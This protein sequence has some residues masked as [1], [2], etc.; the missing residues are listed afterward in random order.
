MD[1]AAE[2]QAFVDTHRE[3]PWGHYLLGTALA[4]A[5]ILQF[6]QAVS[7]VSVDEDRGEAEQ[8]A[9]R[10]YGEALKRARKALDQ[11]LANELL[12]PRQRDSVLQRRC[13]VFVLANEPDEADRDWNEAERLPGGPERVARNSWVLLNLSITRLLVQQGKLTEA[14]GRL[15]RAIGKFPAS[16]LPPRTRAELKLR[17]KRLS[18]ED[19]DRIIADADTAIKLH[20]ADPPDVKARDFVLRARPLD[21]QKKFGDVIQTCDSA[22]KLSPHNLDAYQWKIGALLQLGRNIDAERACRAALELGPG[23]SLLHEFHGRVLHALEQLPAAIDEYGQA[24]GL[25]PKRL[26]ARLGRGWAYLSMDNP[27]LAQI[28]FQTVLEVDRNSADAH[29]GLATALAVQC[30][31]EPAK[32]HAKAALDLDNPP[33]ALTRYRAARVYALTASATRLY[34][35]FA[36]EYELAQMHLTEALERTP[37]ERQAAFCAEVRNDGALSGLWKRLGSD[38]LRRQFGMVRGSAETNSTAAGGRPIHAGPTVLKAPV[39]AGNAGH[40]SDRATHGR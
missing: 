40:P 13:R 17:E 10:D 23:R 15:A 27:Q 8:K 1:A 37:P 22:L 29:C 33:T 6:R 4:D 14:E 31:R 34:D 38:N 3:V 25:E 36:P 5:A 28:D 9:E 21:E 35:L 32:A 7:T 18:P 2:I 11:A 19:R 20:D 39:N 30:D 24:L 16:P 12:T 26:T